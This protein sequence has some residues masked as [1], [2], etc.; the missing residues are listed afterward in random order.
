MRGKSEKRR[1]FIGELAAPSDTIDGL[2]VVING[3]SRN[4]S[5]EEWR[6]Q[7]PSHRIS[8]NDLIV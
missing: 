8:L 2:T 5:D 4:L 1:A 7:H 3:R 6:V